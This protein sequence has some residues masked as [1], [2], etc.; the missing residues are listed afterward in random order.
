MADVVAQASIADH[1]E[2]I[3][4]FLAA[5][6]VTGDVSTITTGTTATITAN[7]Q[8]VRASMCVQATIQVAPDVNLVV[9][10]AKA[11]SGSIVF[12]VKNTGSG[13]ATA[14]NTTIAYIATT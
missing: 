9:V 13:T 2:G 4:P 10:K 14:G 8:N 3:T 6:T 12:T 1:L 5:G 11:G 7:D